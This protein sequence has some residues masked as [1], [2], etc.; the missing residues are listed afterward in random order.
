[1]VVAKRATL[2]ATTA[3][4]PVSWPVIEAADTWHPGHALALSPSP[5]NPPGN[6]SPQF[7][8][9]FTP[10]TAC[11]FNGGAASDGEAAS[12]CVEAGE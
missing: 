7:N 11:F 1:V 6:N 4:S 10:A 2:A 9:A 12:S 5:D 3:S 8:P